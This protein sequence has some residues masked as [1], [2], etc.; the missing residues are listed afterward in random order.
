LP[1]LGDGRMHRDIDWIVTLGSAVFAAL[2]IGTIA[3]DEI[4]MTVE[5][6]RTDALSVAG[7][8]FAT[9]AGVS[10]LERRK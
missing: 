1:S 4:G 5:A 3:Y 2:F 7:L 8:L 9:V 6:I 10:F